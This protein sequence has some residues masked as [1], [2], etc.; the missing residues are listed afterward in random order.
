MSKN[1]KGLS[2][3]VVTLYEPDGND[4]FDVYVTYTIYNEE[5]VMDDSFGDSPYI[6]REDIDIKHYESNNDEDL[7]DWVNDDL[8]YDS[9]LDELEEESEWK[10]EEEE[11]DFEDD[12]DEEEDDN[13]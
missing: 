8:V 13:W 5:E 4:E 12:D 2:T 6:T 1:K 10:D 11:T 3:K 9:L 7:P